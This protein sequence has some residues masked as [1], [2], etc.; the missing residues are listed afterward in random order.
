MAD[1]S[2][3]SDN[4]TIIA[5]LIRTQVEEAQALVSV[6]ILDSPVTEEDVTFD[7]ELDEGVADE[8]WAEADCRVILNVRLLCLA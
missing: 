2:I 5:D 1:L 7:E 6:D 8:E 3:P 4:I